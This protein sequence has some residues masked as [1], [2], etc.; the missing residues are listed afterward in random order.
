MRLL[1]VTQKVD[2]SDGNLGFFVRWLARFA[3]KA[4]LTVIANEV[5]AHELPASVRVYSLGKEGGASRLSRVLAY[6]RILL[7]LLPNT[8]GV[9]FHMCPEYALGAHLLPRL[10]GV[11]TV[12][13]YVHKQVSLRLRLATMLVHA[14]CTASKES[15]RLQSRKVRVIGHGIDTELFSGKKEKETGLRLLSVGRT[16]PVKDLR[17]LL[18]GFFK[19]QKKYAEASLSFVGETVTAQDTAYQGELSRAIQEHSLQAKARFAGKVLYADLP[20]LYSEHTLFVHASRTGSVD[21]VVLEALASGL[22]VFTSSEA[23]GEDIPGVWKF[24]EGEGGKLAEVIS[25]VFES[26]GI[27]YTTKGREWVEKHHS[28]DGLIDAILAVYP[29]QK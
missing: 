19:L 22:P 17:T 7:R 11:C 21:K 5:G 28:Q 4:E 24:P 12:L 23:F 16:A 8:D 29:A 9:F 27:V 10:F 20:K 6:Q 25:R 18:I 3:E 13:W 15:F 26:G 1:I 2:A 14:V